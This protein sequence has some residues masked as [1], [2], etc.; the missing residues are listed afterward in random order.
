MRPSLKRAH[1]STHS[2]RRQVILRPQSHPPTSRRCHLRRLIRRSNGGNDL[3]LAKSNREPALP[4][5]PR[6]FSIAIRDEIECVCL[7]H[8]PTHTKI[9]I[10]LPVVTREV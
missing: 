4:T 6:N 5:A 2:S 3:T 9:E 1:L 10:W 7:R 8:Q